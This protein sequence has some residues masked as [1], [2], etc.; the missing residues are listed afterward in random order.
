MLVFLRVCPLIED[1]LR[2]NSVKVAVEPQAAGEW[3]RTKL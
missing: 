2:H 3:F 1:K